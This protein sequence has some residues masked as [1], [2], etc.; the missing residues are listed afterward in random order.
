[1]AVLF[2]ELTQA[3]FSTPGQS[4]RFHIASVYARVVPKR[5]PILSGRFALQIKGR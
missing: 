3:Q 5:E 1:M 4:R 2:E